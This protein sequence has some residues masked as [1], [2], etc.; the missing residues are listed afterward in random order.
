MAFN[1]SVVIRTLGDTG[2]K[3]RK[4]LEAISHQTIAPTEIV[5][6]I[7]HGY[8]LDYTLGNER[9]IYSNKGM[10]SQRAVGMREAKCDYLLVVDDDLDFPTDF[11]EKMY[12]HLRQNDLD[13]V[14]AF[15][16][17]YSLPDKDQAKQI[18]FKT[19][20]KQ[21]AKQIRGAFTGQVFYSRRRSDYFDTITRTAGHRAFLNHKEKLCQTGCFQC[22]FIK[23]DSAVKVCFEEERW[24]EQGSLS[25][26]AAFDDTVF[27]YKLFLLG[28]KI[29]YAAGTNYTHLDAA[30][31]RVAKDKVT[32]KRIRLYSIARNRTVFWKRFV[33][34]SRPG[35]LTWLGGIYGLGNYALY[36]SIINL[37]PRNWP[38][39]AALF[40]GYRDAFRL[41]SQD[42]ILEKPLWCSHRDE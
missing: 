23:K 28:G 21:L 29:A 4:M 38:A 14:L 1:Y 34:S 20:L 42:D 13:C 11:V 41:L 39:I 27:F 36:S 2:E 22:F 24:L 31:G 25:Q 10:V 5:V 3:Y 16:D 26:Y 8:S 40:A 33:L 9:V 6:V 7:P 12:E 15:G 37:L 19:N 18:S 32:A 30:A 17:Y 35:L